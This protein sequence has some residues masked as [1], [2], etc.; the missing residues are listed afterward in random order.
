[1]EVEQYIYACMCFKALF[2]LSALS[3]P[4]HWIPLVVAGRLF[5][6]CSLALAFKP[7]IIYHCANWTW[8]QE[9][10]MI[11]LPIY[12][13]LF[14]LFGCPQSDG[15]VG[16]SRKQHGCQKERKRCYFVI[17]WHFRH[18]SWLAVGTKKIHTYVCIN[19][20]IGM[21]K[22]CRMRKQ[23]CQESRISA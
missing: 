7:T 20:V 18:F 16:K 6:E 4:F 3:C 10:K 12:F 13:C 5:E 15:E 2:V 22:E 9:L 11:F 21:N 8:N 19:L 17:Y 14:E 1:M 23:P